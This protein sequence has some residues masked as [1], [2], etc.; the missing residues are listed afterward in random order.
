MKTLTLNLINSHYHFIM[1]LA[2]KILPAMAIILLSCSNADAQ[3]DPSTFPDSITIPGPVNFKAGGVKRFLLGKNYRKEWSQPIRVKVFD[4]RTESGGL[5]PLELGGGKQTKSLRLSDANGKEYVLRSVVKSVSDASLQPELQGIPIVKALVADG[6]SASYPYAALSVPLLTEAVGVPHASPKLVYVPDDTLLGAFRADFSNTLC[7]FEERDPVTVK[8]TYNTEDIEKKLLKDNDNAVDQKAT[9]QARLLDMFIM[10]FD[11]HEKQWRWAQVDHEN[12]KTFYPIPRDRDQPFFVNEGLIPFFASRSW[13]APQVQGFRAKARNI[14]TFNWPA[15]NFDR[16]YINELTGTD[17][18]TAAQ[19]LVNSMTD[20]LI[21]KTL[22]QQPEEIRSYA[23][24]HIIATLKER[25]KYFVKEAMA[26]YKFLSKMV[27][28]TGS[29]K[30]ELFDVQRNDDGSV[31][32]TV[33]KINKEAEPTKKLY[34]RKFISGETKEIRLYGMGADDKFMIHGKG[35]AITVRIIGGD[36]E[37]EFENNA[38]AP[39]GKTRIYDLKQGSN[40]FTG[41]G[42]YRSFLSADSGVNKTNRHG[43]KYNVLAPFIAVAYNPDDG[44]YLGASVK[45]TAQGFR[46]QPFKQQHSFS[47]VHSLATHAFNFRYNLEAIDAIGKADLILNTSIKAPKNTTN[48]FKF[49]NETGFD[50]TTN[51]IKYYRVRFDLADA[52]LLLRGNIAKDISIAAGP[53]FQYFSLDSDLNINRLINQTISNGLNS[54]TLYKTKTYAGLH[55][56]AGVDTRN[57]GKDIHKNKAIPSRGIN[58]QTT[59]APYMGLNSLSNNFSQ[60]NSDLSLFFSF[61]KKAN[62]VIA[63]RIG[64]GITFGEYEFYQA[65]YLSGAEN[66]RG[67]RKYRFAGDKMLYHNLD[68]RI[69]IADLRTYLFPASIGLLGFHDIGRVWVKGE[70]SS[71]WHEGYGGGIWFAPLRRFV[72]TAFYSYGDDGGLPVVAFGFQF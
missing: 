12:G 61:N 68:L 34:E 43:F 72:I 20:E 25:K 50:K 37:D 55:L 33:F 18:Q 26:Y 57:N 46:K 65:Q 16:N 31:T 32:V 27:T 70:S 67:Y 4:M 2:V 6:I 30:K 44:V 9:L 7:M 5:T 63:T 40:K 17:W 66:L 8:K 52:S 38:L 60:L 23:M 49:G 11:R 69:K 36:G 10:D 53:A 14:N 62:V 39:A 28:V 3:K 24:N 48:F 64:A 22:Q 19:V 54:A 71:K 29:D 51:T 35:G 41:N 13:V 58:W 45:Y 15:R 47:I 42:N 1:Q 21:E 59:F 56:V